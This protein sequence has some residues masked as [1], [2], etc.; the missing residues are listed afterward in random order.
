L[1]GYLSDEEVLECAQAIQG[2]GAVIVFAKKLGRSSADSQQ[3]ALMSAEKEAEL[4]EFE[5]NR[6]SSREA[7]WYKDEV[8]MQIISW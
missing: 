8:R 7:G 2:M 4:R 6:N 5:V 1:H 3:E